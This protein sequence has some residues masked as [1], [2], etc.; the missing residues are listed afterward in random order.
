[1]DLPR[2]ATSSPKDSSGSL[3]LS[4]CM[5]FILFIHGWVTTGPRSGAGEEIFPLTGTLFDLGN[6]N[7]RAGH[8]P[9][10]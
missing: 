4:G 3:M 8:P 9:D 7:I 5:A 2:A 1:M 6:N 10:D